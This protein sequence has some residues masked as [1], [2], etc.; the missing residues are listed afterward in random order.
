MGNFSYFLLVHLALLIRRIAFLLW[1]GRRNM[2]TKPQFLKLTASMTL[3]VLQEYDLFTRKDF[4]IYT[5]LGK[6][7]LTPMKQMR[8][9][10][11][12]FVCMIWVTYSWS[13]E[14]CFQLRMVRWLYSS[15]VG[16]HMRI[17]ELKRFNIL[18]NPILSFYK[19]V[20]IYRSYFFSKYYAG[21]KWKKVN[22][23]T[24]HS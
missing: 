14:Y 18:S 21:D 6:V 1:Q 10:H 12:C 16:A 5:R 22:I 8:G 23:R 3:W 15:I 24:Q 20:L 7:T 19:E 4:V 11:M 13:R 2:S 9:I 17:P